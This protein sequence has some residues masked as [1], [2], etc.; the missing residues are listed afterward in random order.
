MHIGNWKKGLLLTP[1]FIMISLLFI[2]IIGYDS[3]LIKLYILITLCL[4][5]GLFVSLLLRSELQ[6]EWDELFIINIVVSSILITFTYIFICIIPIHTDQTILFLSLTILSLSTYIVFKQ[7]RIENPAQ[8]VFPYLL[9]CFGLFFSFVVGSTQVL[10]ILPSEYW[11]GFDT[12]EAVNVVAKISELGLSPEEAFHYYRQFVSL[13]QFGF[14]Y[15]LS[16]I[17]LCTG[18]SIDVI[19]RYGP[20]VLSGLASTLFYLFLKRREGFIVGLFG[21]TVIFVNPRLN[22]RFSMLLR[23]NYA[24]VLMITLILLFLLRDYQDRKFKPFFSIIC[25]LV[26][27]GVIYSHPTTTIICLAT[28]GLYLVLHALKGHKNAFRE[29]VFI[30]VAPF[31]TILPFFSIMINSYINY[32]EYNFMNRLNFIYLIIPITLLAS[33]IL[34]KKRSFFLTLIPTYQRF[35]VVAFSVFTITQAIMFPHHFV[36]NPAYSDLSINRFSSTLNTLAIIGVFLSVFDPIH[37]LIYIVMVTLSLILSIS[38]IGV[39]VPLQR[40]AIYI[41]FIQTYCAASVL[42]RISDVIQPK[43]L[44]TIN[45]RFSRMNQRAWKEKI[46]I[47]IIIMVLPFLYIEAQAEITSDEIRYTREDIASLRAFLETVGENEVIIPHLKAEIPLYYIDTPIEML[48][49]TKEERYWVIDTYTSNDLNMSLSSLPSSWKNK[50]KLHVVSLSRYYYD[51]AYRN[52]LPFGEILEQ[53]CDRDFWGTAVVFTFDLPF[54]KVDYQLK[55]VK[56]ITEASGGSILTGENVGWDEMLRNP[57]N[58]VKIQ[59][60]DGSYLQMAYTGVDSDGE[61]RIGFAYSNDGL[62]WEKGEGAVIEQGHDNPFLVEVDGCLYLFCEREED[63]QIVR[64]KSMDGFNWGN[65]TT[66]STG[67]TE[68]RYSI[69]EAPVIWFEEGKWKMVFT[70][71]SANDES[72]EE[73]IV[74]V[75]SDDGEDW[76][77]NPEFFNWEFFYVQENE[78]ASIEKV[79]LDDI[80]ITDDGYLFTGKYF[81]TY[82]W[83]EQKQGT[84]SF[85][86]TS[87]DSRGA[88]M[89]PLN[90]EDYGRNG[91]KID[92]VHPYADPLTGIIKFIYIDNDRV[93]QYG[94]T[95]G[96]RIGNIRIW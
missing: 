22:E 6:I 1:V 36:G 9:Q 96:I 28:L 73:G 95:E 10:R 57:S 45:Y 24:Y 72:V 89:T 37:E 90:Y 85:F 7:K 60:A 88:K 69:R 58:I 94:I 8:D 27:L 44:N 46:V 87:L 49:Q 35:I 56:Y 51:E 23:E 25:S 26:L 63:H 17:Q 38:R 29:L 43:F 68:N 54:K 39:L 75:E 65:E 50:T 20:I 62:T 93:G 80:A 76:T 30:L 92:S 64:Y 15:L 18:I 31:L 78:E 81:S 86:I 82:R 53:V 61:S 16:A 47:F 67:V 77:K 21:S 14:Y 4:V 52:T 34:Y 66:V 3:I 83:L 84:A 48:V 12:W 32:V 11:Y 91:D 33:T 42:N 71:V 13:S 79:L 2:D 40:L 70:E 74:Y 19:M 59:S 41:S 55:Y 5:P